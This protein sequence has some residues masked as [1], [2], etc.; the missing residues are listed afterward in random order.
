M[1]S[2]YHF[3]P[4]N[5]LKIFLW[6]RWRGAAGFGID[7]ENGGEKSK[8]AKDMKSTE[9]SREQKSNSKGI[10]NDSSQLGNI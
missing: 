2:L 3:F 5:F 8:E 9:V 7:F 4:L 6:G 10:T 1:T